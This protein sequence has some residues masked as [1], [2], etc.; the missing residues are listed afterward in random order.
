MADRPAWRTPPTRANLAWVSA[1]VGPGAR[2]LSVASLRGGVA[3][4][5]D[6]VTVDSA[7]GRR[8]RLVLQRWI[9]PGWE[10]DDV[11]FD[12]AKEAVVLEL[13]AGHEIPVPS[14][15]AVDP[16]GS[17]AGVPCLL[18]S[19]LD[20]GPPT[21]RKVSR[22]AVLDA[23]GRTLA[24][25]QRVGAAAFDARPGAQHSLPQYE[26]FGDLASATVPSLSRRP[27]LWTAARTAAAARPPRGPATFLHRDF[28]PGNTLWIGD[29]LS[30]V[31]DWTSASLGPAAADLAHLRVNLVVLVGPDAADDA[32]A[33]F[34]AAGGVAHGGR[35]HDLRTV[36]DFLGDAPP[37]TT[38][39][40]ALDRLEAYL[41]RVLESSDD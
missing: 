30:G 41:T 10:T 33:A 35:H 14:L 31:V 5:T 40:P 19:R 6:A 25:I 11:G 15:V 16:D 9:R 21:A 2:V 18:T 29:R 1:I 28:H 17:A 26:P 13:L 7:A 20:G 24:A 22:P 32:R 23:L 36:F 39:D 12:P 38:V 27:K 34:L 37:G 4:A 8:H 3:Q